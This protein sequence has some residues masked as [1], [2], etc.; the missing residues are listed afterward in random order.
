[1]A[2]MMDGKVRK[3]MMKARKAKVMMMKVM[4]TM[5]E[6]KVMKMMVQARTAMVMVTMVEVKVMVK[7]MTMGRC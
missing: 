6:G 7:A 1:M 2:T 3:M 5:V 4:V